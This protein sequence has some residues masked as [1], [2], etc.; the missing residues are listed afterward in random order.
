[1]SANAKRLLALVL[2]L[3]LTLALAGCGKQAGQ[4]GAGGTAA[5]NA[6]EMKMSEFS[7]TPKEVRV[8][9]GQPVTLTLVNQGA[10]SHNLVIDA[11]GVKSPD[12][13]AG[14]KGEVTFTPNQKGSFKIY[15]S[16]PGHEASGM[17]ATLIVD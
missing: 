8:K 13:Q 17:T 7:F 5:S 4:G 15:C 9:G 10:D 1:M 16:M 11:F 14:Q 2:G 3:V 6:V 12:V